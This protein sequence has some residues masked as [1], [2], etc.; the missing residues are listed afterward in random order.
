MTNQQLINLR[1]KLHYITLLLLSMILSG[2]TFCQIESK[3]KPKPKTNPAAT[4]TLQQ[5]PFRNKFTLKVAANLPCSVFVDGE[6]RGSLIPEK[7][8]KIQLNSGKYLLKFISTDNSQD[9]FSEIFTV[10]NDM[11]N[12]EDIRSVDLLNIKRNRE[13]KEKREAQERKKEVERLRLIN[14]AGIEM[15]LIKGGKIQLGNIKCAVSKTGQTVIVNDFYIGKYE[16][17]EKQWREI[18]GSD[19]LELYHPNCDQCPVN[20]I[21]ANDIQAFLDK[22]NARSGLKYRLPTEAEWEFAA[23]GGEYSNG[24]C[25]SGSDNIDKVAWYKN[26][27]DP[28]AIIALGFSSLNTHP[29]GEKAGNELGLFD[30]SGNVWEICTSSLV[31]RGGAW[32]ENKEVVQIDFRGEWEPNTRKAAIGFRVARSE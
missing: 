6:N 4:N 11:V 8:I 27:N 29:V 30:M 18:M 15:A 2:N 28:D 23:R 21:T 24:F 12:S 31:I 13:D 9:F 14:S 26:Q 16:L 17:T 25:F 22:L 20:S 19:L 7:I 5:K 10:S 1:M 32:N 3:P